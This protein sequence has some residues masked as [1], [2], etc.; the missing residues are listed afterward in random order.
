MIHGAAI[1]T[2]KAMA[3][4]GALTF[5]MICG[6]VLMCWALAR[7]A[8]SSRERVQKLPGGLWRQ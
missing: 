2:S 3:I 6:V 4:L 5:L 8:K 1:G 7:S